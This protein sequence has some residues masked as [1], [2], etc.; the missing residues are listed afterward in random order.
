M[1]NGNR[2]RALLTLLPVAAA[3]LRLGFNAVHGADFTELSQ[4][5]NLALGAGEDPSDLNL[6]LDYQLRH[7]LMDEFQDTSSGQI[8]LLRK[9]LAG[10]EPGDGR[11]LFLVGDPMQSIYRFREAEVGIFMDVQEQGIDSVLPERLTL[12]A[13]FRSAP[14]LVDWFNETFHKVMPARRSIIHGAV[15]YTLASPYKAPDK[16]AQVSV[17]AA[18][19]RDNDA[20]AMAVVNCIHN[21]LA[22][23]PEDSIAVLG[24]SR[25]HLAHI[26]AELNRR[27]I[28][29]QGVKLEHLAERQAVQDLL[30][31]VLVLAQPA[32]DVAWLGLLRSPWTGALVRRPHRPAR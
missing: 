3:Q 25:G 19:R 17:H 6:A 12:T 23:F 9:L 20:E 4:R 5:A 32:D 1:V 28:P 8:E 30:A 16:G 26:V 21:T 22:D 11:S 31:L 10:W 13:N 27:G 15:E 14:V 24:R 29:F 18:I 2:S 7:I